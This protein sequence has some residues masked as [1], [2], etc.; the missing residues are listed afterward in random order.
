MSRDCSYAIGVTVY[1]SVMRDVA[2]GDFLAC[3]G[4]TP[5]GIDGRAIKK[6]HIPV[7]I[8]PDAKIRCCI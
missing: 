6:A 1:D 8:F 4:E 7:G 2:K 3:K 5:Y